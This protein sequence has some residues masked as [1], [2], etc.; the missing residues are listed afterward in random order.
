MHSKHTVQ[1]N[2]S[3]YQC[4]SV[5]VYQFFSVSVYQCFSIAGLHCVLQC[6]LPHTWDSFLAA[7]TGGLAGSRWCRR[8]GTLGHS[9]VGHT[10]GGPWSSTPYATQPLTPSLST[11][12]QWSILDWC[13]RAEKGGFTPALPD[14]KVQAYRSELNKSLISTIVPF[15]NI[16][17]FMTN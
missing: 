8:T 17:T 3:V 12:L 5:S 4:F 13:L 7:S 1:H 11:R 2:V 6:C 14:S 9:E 15:N 16:F 10:A